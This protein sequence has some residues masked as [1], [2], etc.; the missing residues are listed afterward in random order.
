MLGQFSLQYTKYCR[1]KI[2]SARSRFSL[3]KAGSENAHI[4][5][6]PIFTLLRCC[7]FQASALLTFPLFKVKMIRTAMYT[8]LSPVTVK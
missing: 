1:E 6:Q 8:F 5:A 4:S 3:L 2:A 7:R